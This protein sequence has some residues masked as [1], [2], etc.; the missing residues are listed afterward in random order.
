MRGRLGYREGRIWG[1]MLLGWLLLL[2]AA[3]AKAE[4]GSDPGS[5]LTGYWVIHDGSAVV[6]IER[7]AAGPGY[8][9]S[10]ASVLREHAYQGLVLAEG[11]QLVG[12]QFRGRI[13]EPLSGHRYRVRMR[14]AEDN[15]LEV[16]AFIGFSVLGQTMYWQRLETY[17]RQHSQMLAALPA[18]RVF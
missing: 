5:E 12:G 16:R 9:V 7:E 8:Q 13:L 15:F 6:Q 2:A 1:G 14:A 18:A 17:R 3:H 11:L 4:P 10:V